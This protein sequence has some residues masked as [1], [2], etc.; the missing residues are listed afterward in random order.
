MRID[1]KELSGLNASAYLTCGSLERTSHS[2]GLRYIAT[3]YDKLCARLAER[4][5]EGF[6]LNTREYE[7]ESHIS[8]G[9]TTLVDG[10]GLLYPGAPGAGARPPG[11]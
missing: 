6:T 3:A 4:E 5:Y 7:G 11:S 2:P 1:T 9:L 10:I 8:V